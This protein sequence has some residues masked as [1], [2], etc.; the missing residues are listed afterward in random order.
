MW[1][2]SSIRFDVAGRVTLSVCPR[3]KNTKPRRNAEMKVMFFMVN[4]MLVNKKKTAN[5][6][7]GINEKRKSDDEFNL[8]SAANLRYFRAKVNRYGDIYI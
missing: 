7:F 5:L 8:I 6:G 2:G 1:S 4:S 3:E